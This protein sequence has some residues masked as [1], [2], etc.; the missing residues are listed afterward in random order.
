MT[1]E[2]LKAKRKEVQKVYLNQIQEINLEY[3]KANNKIAVG[4]IIED[5]IGVGEVL[6]IQYALGWDS[7]DNIPSCIYV[8]WNLTKAGTV[9]K[10]EPKRSIYQTNLINC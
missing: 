5:H 4:D 7:I 1:K 10:R 6:F 2:E 8:C 9:S 3:A